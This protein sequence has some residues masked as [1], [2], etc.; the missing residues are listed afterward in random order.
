MAKLTLVELTN[1]RQYFGQLSR[2]Y[3]MFKAI[4]SNEEVIECG[5][6]I[7]SLRR[8]GIDTN[9]LNAL[10]GCQIVTKVYTDDRTGEL[11]NPEDRIQ[12]ILDGKATLVL[13]NSVNSSFILSETYESNQKE[14][15]A[16]VEAKVQVEKDRERTR[17]DKERS[18]Q[19]ALARVQALL[20]RTENPE[21]ASNT[22]A[23]EVNM[24]LA[25]EDKF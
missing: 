7:N 11:M 8:K 21:P 5:I 17:I 14:L 1:V 4:T 20:N 12:M 22:P 23:P 13:F 18:A 3:C 15:L 24:E 2:E 10:V 9:N 19:R 25:E 16:T 6:T